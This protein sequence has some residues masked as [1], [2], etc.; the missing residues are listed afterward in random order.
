MVRVEREGQ[1]QVV[2]HPE[3][4]GLE[5]RP[6]HGVGRARPDGAFQDHHL[7]RPKLPGDR[8]AGTGHVGQV[9]LPRMVERRRHADQDDVG[10]G[11]HGGIGAGAEPAARHRVRDP[12]FGEIRDH[13]LA[14][15]DPRN[16]AGV[17]IEAGDGKARLVGG[18]GQRQPDISKADG[19]HRG[20]ARRNAALQR[21]GQGK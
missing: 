21:S 14:G 3:A 13:P 4:A 10:R 11:Q 9:R 16:A 8:L 1:E 15:I 2:A 18:Q 12:G 5:Q 17:E 6:Q 7:P 19:D 20:F